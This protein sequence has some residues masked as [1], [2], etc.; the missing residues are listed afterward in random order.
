LLLRPRC[1]VRKRS[2]LETRGVSRL[3]GDRGT[4]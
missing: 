2:G 3:S 1:D 4:T